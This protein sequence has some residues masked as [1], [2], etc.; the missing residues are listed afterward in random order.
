[1][2]ASWR[3]F[4]MGAAPDIT[5][6]MEARSSAVTRG[7][8]AISTTMGGTNGATVT[9]CLRVRSTSAPRSNLRMITIADPARSPASSTE[10]SE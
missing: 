5:M 3:S 10:L 9:P 6:R 4:P 1:M 7:L 2:K 8:L